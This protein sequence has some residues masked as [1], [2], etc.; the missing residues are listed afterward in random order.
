MLFSSE[1]GH[2]L[3][4]MSEMCCSV[5]YCPL[6]HGNSYG[7]CNIQFQMSV[8]FDCFTQR[9]VNILGELFAHHFVV[10]DQAAV[11]FRNTF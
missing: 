11:N 1:T 3:E 2:W 6:F 5:F 7:I 10:K 4:P 8:I 9:F